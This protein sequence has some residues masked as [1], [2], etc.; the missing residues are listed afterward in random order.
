MK[1]LRN[2][3]VFSLTEV[4]SE[5]SCIEREFMLDVLSS[6]IGRLLS[7]VMRVDRCSGAASCK[8]AAGGQRHPDV[9]AYDDVHKVVA[10]TEYASIGSEGECFSG[11]M[12]AIIGR[13]IR[14][15][16]SQSV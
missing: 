11:K 5:S 9:A 6:V 13:E 15:G 16:R 2:Y 1:S 14:V 12:G 10:T 8:R 3:S 7:S 4:S